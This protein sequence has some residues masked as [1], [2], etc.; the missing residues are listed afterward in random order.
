M[1]SFVSTPVVNGLGSGQ[2]AT[3]TNNP[4]LVVLVSGSPATNNYASWL[5]NYP[6]LTGADT[7]G[8][9]DPDGDGFINNT[10]FAFDGNPTVDT[11][12]L[13]TATAVGTNAV[14]NWI[15]RT[16]GVTYEVQ[17]NS[18]LTTAWTSTGIIGVVASNQSGVLL[19]PEYVRKQFSTNA[20]GKDFYRVRATIP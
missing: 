17:K 3:V 15:E 12:A 18:S 1:N 11:P 7:N 8:S 19:P 9:A 20:S 2:A 5:A 14:F 10:E 16:N 6:S 4:N 13:M